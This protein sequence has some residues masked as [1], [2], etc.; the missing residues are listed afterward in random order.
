MSFSATT[1][2]EAPKTSSTTTL[3]PAKVTTTEKAESKDA[4]KVNKTDAPPPPDKQG[5]E[6]KKPERKKS[7]RQRL[8]EHL[9][10][11]GYDRMAHPRFDASQNVTV[12]SCLIDTFGDSYVKVHVEILL[13][14]H[15]VVTQSGNIV[16]GQIGLYQL[17][18]E[19]MLALCFL[20]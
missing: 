19:K 1:T 14:L 3:P 10:Q 6:D 18:Q 8:R 13:L 20:R 2:T 4:D 5:E 9:L 11:G 16:V 12:R 7:H 17:L 15:P